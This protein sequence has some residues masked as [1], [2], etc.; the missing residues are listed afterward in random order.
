MGKHK[1]KHK[2]KYMYMYMY[3]TALISL[4]NWPWCKHNHKHMQQH[5]DQKFSFLTCLCLSRFVF[6][7]HVNFI[8]WFVLTLV[9][10]SLM[11]RGLWIKVNHHFIAQTLCQLLFVFVFEMATER[12]S[13]MAIVYSP[14][15]TK[16][17]VTIQIVS[18]LS[19]SPLNSVRRITRT[20][21]LI[22]HDIVLN[23][24]Q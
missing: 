11:K 19:A 2:C 20:S 15:V 18:V 14:N 23:V 12:W 13:T 4:R 21:A 3:I 8:L 7:W 24:I 17:N 5:K 16:I 1:G 6:I 22:I 9:L 10:P